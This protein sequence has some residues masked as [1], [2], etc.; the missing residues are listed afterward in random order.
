MTQKQSYYL[1]GV[2]LGGCSCDWGCPC[3]F[4]VAPSR[5]YCDGEY[6]W[7]VDQGHYGDTSLDGVRFAMF[8][9][10]PAAIHLGDLTS[11]AVVDQSASPQ[12]RQALE[13]MFRNAP[14]FNVFLDLSSSF[15]GISYAPIEVHRDGI[16]SRVNIPGIY[17]LELTPM[18]NPVTG[19]DELATLLKPTGFTANES[20]LCSTSVHRLTLPGLSYEHPGCYG[21]FAP[22]EYKEG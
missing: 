4:E 16:H 18:T 20:E 22:Y 3:N 10:S 19:E 21:E 6:V 17:D 7:T 5:G 14:P 8:F 1:K 15:L 2:N 13:A 9:H 12:Q 11:A